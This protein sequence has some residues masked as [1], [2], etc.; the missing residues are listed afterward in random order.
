MVGG[1]VSQK[2]GGA[3]GYRIV[4]SRPDF[5]MAETVN[6]LMSVLNVLIR[7]HNERVDDFI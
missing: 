6:V 4:Q 5:T 1:A 2:S 3:I 7:Y